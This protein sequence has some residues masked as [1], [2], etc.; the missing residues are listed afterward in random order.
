M[1]G[2][3]LCVIDAGRVDY[4]LVG[5][6]CVMKAGMAAMHRVGGYVLWRRG[7]QLCIKLAATSHGGGEVGYT[8][9]IMRGDEKKTG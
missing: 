6:L 7:W 3:R 1:S 4:A 5:R 8:P 2:G 9:A